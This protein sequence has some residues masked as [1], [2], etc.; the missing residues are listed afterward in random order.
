MLFRSIEN[1]VNEIIKMNLPVAVEYMPTQEAAAIVDLSKLPD[2]V[3]DTLRIV[4]VG[5]YDACACAGDHVIN[6]QEIGT[7]KIISV[8]STKEDG[9]EHGRW[10]VRFKLV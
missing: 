8:D 10:R 2:G 7:F 9:A 4:K 3:S 1:K 5:D 6:T